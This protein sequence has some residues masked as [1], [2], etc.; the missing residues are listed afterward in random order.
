[1]TDKP[2]DA[3]ALDQSKK[4][5]S[6]CI[7]FE[8]AEGEMQTVNASDLLAVYQAGQSARIHQLAS[9]GKDDEVFEPHGWAQTHGP[10]INAFTQEFDIAESWAMAGYGTVE[11]LN[12]KHVD[13][14]IE[15]IHA[16]HHAHVAPLEAELADLK[17]LKEY[18]TRPLRERCAERDTLLAR[19]AEL[20]AQQPQ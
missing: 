20:E 2:L 6:A 16:E 18:V 5:I 12:R 7:G 17:H 10:A 19:I 1:M 15:R 11:L 8:F 4:A 14:E 9:A 3:M 13:D